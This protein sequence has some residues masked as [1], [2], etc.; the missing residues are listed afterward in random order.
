MKH[1]VMGK[2]NIFLSYYTVHIILY[3][4]ILYYKK[5]KQYIL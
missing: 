1:V 5:L 2:K 4:I 3:Y